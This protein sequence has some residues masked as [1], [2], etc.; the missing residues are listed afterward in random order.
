[1]FFQINEPDGDTLGILQISGVLPGPS[2]I[3]QKVRALSFEAW[4]KMYSDENN[5]QANDY[6]W[7]KLIT[8]LEALGWNAD[9]VF[10][11]TISL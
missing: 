2:T 6:F 9:R 8:S 10:I 7:D 4:D 5:G 3:E 1:M 11:E